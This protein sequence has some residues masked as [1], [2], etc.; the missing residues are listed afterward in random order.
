MFY[1][2]EE[3]KLL[4]IVFLLVRVFSRVFDFV[5]FLYGILG[6]VFIILL[7]FNG[8]IRVGRKGW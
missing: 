5:K 4:G 3:F 1:L 2:I 8:S 6:L 7:V